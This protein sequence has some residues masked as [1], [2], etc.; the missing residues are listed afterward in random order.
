MSTLL[1][2]SDCLSARPTS[3]GGPSCGPSRVA[4]GVS[5]FLKAASAATGVESTEDAPDSFGRLASTV[6]PEASRF[7]STSSA[8]MRAGRAAVTGLH[9][10]EATSQAENEN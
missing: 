7:S 6:S 8:E 3:I 4:P 10:P 1:G 2:E 5:S 9:Q